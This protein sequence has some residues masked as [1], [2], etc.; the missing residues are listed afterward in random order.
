MFAD[1]KK[2]AELKLQLAEG[3]QLL[4]DSIT[5]TFIGGNDAS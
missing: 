2:V 4:N 3:M 5:G 1:E